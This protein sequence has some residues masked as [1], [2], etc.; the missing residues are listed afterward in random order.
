M[1]EALASFLLSSY[2]EGA[3]IAEGW[4]VL[5]SSKTTEKAWAFSNL[6]SYDLYGL[7]CLIRVFWLYEWA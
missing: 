2:L 4:E 1:E 7:K 3:V 6:L 5:E